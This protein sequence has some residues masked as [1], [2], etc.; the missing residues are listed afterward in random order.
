MADIKA[1]N[2]EP[3]EPGKKWIIIVGIV[4]MLAWFANLFWGIWAMNNDTT[5][6]G[7]W[8]DIFGAV[9]ALFSGAAF[10]MIFRGYEMQR[11]EV[12][13]AKA[14]L[15]ETKKQTTAQKRALDKQNV[16]TEKQIFENTFFRLL[17]DYNEIVQSLNCTNINV[18][19]AGNYDF[20]NVGED[21][22]KHE[23]KK[24][25]DEVSKLID[26]VFYRDLAYNEGIDDLIARTLRKE[27]KTKEDFDA[28]F[29]DIRTALDGLL[30]RYF[31]TVYNILKLISRATF[32][33]ENKKFYANLLR[34]QMTNKETKVL[35]FNIASKVG[36]EKFLE[37]AVNFNFL[38]HCHNSNGEITLLSKFID[39][40]AFK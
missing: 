1:E 37:L 5:K 8:G 31:R 3:K 18:L 13:L 23:G 33:Q 22:Q 25:F 30:D 39:K 20:N 9:N 40:K 10:L 28:L 29:E 21:M 24:V 27:T 17:D 26:L 7:Q 6:G 2:S 15:A 14:E 11:Y 16:A 4:M 35:A 12:K 38:K 36:R 34:A 19:F 32:Y